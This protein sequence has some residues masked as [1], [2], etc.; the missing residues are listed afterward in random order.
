MPENLFVA[1]K[2]GPGKQVSRLGQSMQLVGVVS[3]VELYIS[4]SKELYVRNPYW[5]ERTAWTAESISICILLDTCV[6]GC[7]PRSFTYHQISKLYLHPDPGVVAAA[8]EEGLKAY[9]SEF[10]ATRASIGEKVFHMPAK[11]KR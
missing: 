9:S 7:I 8:A 4:T 6:R 3:M 5:P 1:L 10:G 11:A 2:I